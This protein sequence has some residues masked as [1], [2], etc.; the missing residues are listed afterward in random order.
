VNAKKCPPRYHDRWSTPASDIMITLPRGAAQWRGGRPAPVAR[1]VA[2]RY[3]QRRR[4]LSTAT[5]QPFTT[6][7]HAPTALRYRCHA[8]G[9]RCAC[10]QPHTEERSE[11]VY[12]GM[13]VMQLG[14]ERSRA[15]PPNAQVP[16]NRRVHTNRVQFNRPPAERR[17]T[18]RSQNV[19]GHPKRPHVDDVYRPSH[20]PGNLK[21]AG[22]SWKGAG[23]GRRQKVGDGE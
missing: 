5:G 12:E 17:R 2:A 18:S 23:G 14:R 15:A 3:V 6:S 9:V 8:D 7:Y 4:S 11:A 19:H 20:P 21:A 22:S 16:T 13:D 1:E 10:I